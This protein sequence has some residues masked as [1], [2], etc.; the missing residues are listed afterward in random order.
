MQE[1]YILR[2]EMSAGLQLCSCCSNLTVP[3]NMVSLFLVAN[4]RTLLIY[5]R[6]HHTLSNSN[7]L[8]YDGVSPL[9]FVL[10]T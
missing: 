10:C 7:F 6:Y 9:H 2:Y 4:E 1:D 8:L 5:T 3:Y